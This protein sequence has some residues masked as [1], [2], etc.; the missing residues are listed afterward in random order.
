MEYIDEILRY[1]T[2]KELKRIR[3]IAQRLIDHK[4]KQLEL[5]K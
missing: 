4:E 2:L 5:I 1:A 3:K